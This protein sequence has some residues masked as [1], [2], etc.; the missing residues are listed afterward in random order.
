MCIQSTPMLKL[1]KS[2]ISLTVSTLSNTGKAGNT[3]RIIEVEQA[4]LIYSNAQKKKKEK[5]K[6]KKKDKREKRRK[7]D[8]KKE[9]KEKK[10]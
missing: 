2:I 3:K 9:R 4:I 1:S 7:R 5:K 8:Q 10:K 6:K